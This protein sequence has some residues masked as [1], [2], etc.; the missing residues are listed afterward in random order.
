LQERTEP[1]TKFTN[2]DGHWNITNV[3]ETC[4]SDGCHIDGI[5]GFYDTSGLSFASFAIVD[6]ELDVNSLYNNK[7]P[8]FSVEFA[9]DKDFSL[10]IDEER[11]ELTMNLRKSEKSLFTFPALSDL[12]ISLEL[13]DDVYADESV[14][15]EVVAPIH[16]NLD[17]PDFIRYSDKGEPYLVFDSLSK[18]FTS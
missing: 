3:I 9:K 16:G 18:N 15:I 14:V 10:H 4:I 12:H 11:E 5:N 17:K 1:I 6:Y 7:T 13:I 8:D 2:I